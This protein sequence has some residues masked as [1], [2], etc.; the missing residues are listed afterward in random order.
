MGRSFEERAW[1]WMRKGWLIE[2]EIEVGRRK[3]RWKEWR[4]KL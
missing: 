4:W 3:V 2:I 1:I